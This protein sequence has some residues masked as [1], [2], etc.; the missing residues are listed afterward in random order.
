MESD[1]VTLQ[2][3]FTFHVDG[4]GTDRKLHGKMV[5]TGLRPHFLDKFEKRG[6]EL[7]AWLRTFEPP[8]PVVQLAGREAA[9]WPHK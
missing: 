8:T 2:D 3:L 9:A 1:M 7:P 4:V 6:V 5:N